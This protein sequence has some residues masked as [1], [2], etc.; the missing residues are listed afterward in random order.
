MCSLIR[1]TFIYRS[2]DS[3]SR[4]AIHVPLP[5]GPLLWISVRSMHPLAFPS[6]ALNHPGKNIRDKIETNENY[7]L[8]PSIPLAFSVFHLSF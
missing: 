5:D 1:K 3:Y 4:D 7:D 8:P 2:E 6:I